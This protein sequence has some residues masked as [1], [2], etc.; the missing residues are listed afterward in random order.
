MSPV[1]HS[2]LTTTV[3]APDEPES[4][5]EIVEAVLPMMREL[6]GFKGVIVLHDD[7]RRLN[8]AMTLWENAEALRASEGLMGKIRAAETNSRHVESQVTSTFRVV[9]CHLER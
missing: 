2:R 5:A 7:D 1:M 9:A 3:L 6:S 4:A 8:V